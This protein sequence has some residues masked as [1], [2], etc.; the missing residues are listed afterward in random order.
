M[1]MLYPSPRNAN[2]FLQRMHVQD[3][4]APGIDGGTFTSG[5]WRTRTLNTIR[6][7]TIAG[8]SLSANTITLPAGRYL[9][10]GS[11]PACK[12]IRHKT[13][14]QNVSDGVTAFE[15]TN[16]VSDFNY[17]SV[18][19]SHFKGLIVLTAP[20]NFQV[21]HACEVTVAN[22]GMGFST[23]SLGNEVYTDVEIIRIGDA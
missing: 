9:I 20:K 11:A 13:W 12:V 15:G 5:A 14:F 16:E 6:E 8:A 17:P 1:T 18:T 4:K 21:L 23:V 19:R 2:R 10:N 7:N 3:V 22:T